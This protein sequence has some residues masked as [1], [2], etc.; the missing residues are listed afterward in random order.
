MSDH[1]TMSELLH[2]PSR[3]SRSGLAGTVSAGLIA[4]VLATMAKGRAEAW[5]QPVAERVWPPTDAEKRVPGADPADH[6]ENMPPSEIAERAVTAVDRD[7]AD[8]ADLVGAV[9]AQLHWGMGLGFAAA[10]AVAAGRYPRLRFGLGAPA[11][12]ALYAATH[13][14]TLPMAGLQP[15]P[16]KMPPAAVAWE[17]GS[18]VVYG[19]AFEALL[20]QQARYTR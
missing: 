13:G 8:D 19:M 18:H 3:P 12:L 2:R 7:E 16:W 9:G 11:G 1:A 10:Y 5:L 17:V 15:R 6:P 14:S 20:R 4:G